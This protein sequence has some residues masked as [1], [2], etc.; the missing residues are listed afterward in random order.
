MVFVHVPVLVTREGKTGTRVVPPMKGQVVDLLFVVLSPA[1]DLRH[2]LPPLTDTRAGARSTRPLPT[3]CWASRGCCRDPSYQP[4]DSSVR[5]TSPE[6]RLALLP[7]PWT[8]RTPP[9]FRVWPWLGHLP[10]CPHTACR[11]WHDP[12]SPGPRRPLRSLR[13]LAQV[14]CVASITGCC[15]AYSCCVISSTWSLY[16]Q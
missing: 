16:N 6:V 4:D 14:S 8:G 5:S 13:E 10:R 1:D 7:C 3:G 9:R 15:A 2:V 12:N 11:T